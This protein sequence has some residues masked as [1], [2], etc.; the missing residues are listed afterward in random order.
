MAYDDLK[1]GDL[2]I[3]TPTTVLSQF[4]DG[5][6]NDPVGPHDEDLDSPVTT[7][8][9]GFTDTMNAMKLKPSAD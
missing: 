8:L 2:I 5:D 9:R 3:Q 4:L 6:I 1:D 7:N